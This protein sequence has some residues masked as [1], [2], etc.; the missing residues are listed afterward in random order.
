MH[1]RVPEDV[2]NERLARLQ[3]AIERNR[4]A[5][6]ARC[7]GATFDVLLEKPGRH[8]GQLVGRTPYLQPIQVMAPMRRIGDLAAVTVTQIGP[9]SLFGTMAR[10]APRSDGTAFTIAAGS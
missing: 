1:G 4:S 10:P 3:A 5:F 7:L 6:N 8:S 9:N 2:K